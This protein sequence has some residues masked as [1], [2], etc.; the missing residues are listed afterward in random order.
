MRR[1]GYW[2]SLRGAPPTNNETAITV[3]I[4]R[5]QVF[6]VPGVVKLMAEI[7]GVAPARAT[8]P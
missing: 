2:L 5:V 6:D 3:K 8:P 1:C 7:A 4:P